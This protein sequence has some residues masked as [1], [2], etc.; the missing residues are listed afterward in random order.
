MPG[1]KDLVVDFN[2]KPT[3]NN[4]IHALFQGCSGSWKTNAAS[5]FPKPYFF[6]FDRGLKSVRNVPWDFE[7]DEYSK[8]LDQVEIKLKLF[9]N[10]CP[11]ETLIFDSATTMSQDVLI[12]FATA[13][14]HLDQYGNASDK[15]GLLEY[16]QRVK[17]F[18]AFV[19]ALGRF[20]VNTIFIC[21]E[22]TYKNQDR[23]ILQTRPA[24]PGE[25]LPD[26]VPVFFDEV[27]HFELT[28]DSKGGQIA[29]VFTS[30]TGLFVAKSRLGVPNLEFKWGDNFFNIL[31]THLKG[32]QPKT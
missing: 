2:A 15:V 20:P 18:T 12:H 3:S 4:R 26:Q 8:K 5:S 17:W 24:L 22:T 27:Y 1:K 19:A 14:G 16:G 23:G 28:K 13:N 11:Y 29:K 25:Q 7:Y 10:E 32:G 30:S 6:D 9:E 21:H 31:M